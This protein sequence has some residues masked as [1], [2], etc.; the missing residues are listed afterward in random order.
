MLS[1]HS[2]SV[3][4]DP[5]PDIVFSLSDMLIKRVVNNTSM[6]TSHV[7]HVVGLSVF[8]IPQISSLGQDV[9]NLLFFFLSERRRTSVS[10]VFF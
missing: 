6:F 1:I 10:A 4:C 8:H 2:R 3:L 9:I 7:D 5:S